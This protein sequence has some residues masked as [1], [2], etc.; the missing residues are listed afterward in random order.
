MILFQLEKLIIL[1]HLVMHV[2]K[3]EILLYVSS[4]QS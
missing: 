2:E 1:A 4:V 3:N